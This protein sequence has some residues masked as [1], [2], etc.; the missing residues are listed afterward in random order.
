M[1]VNVNGLLQ[2]EYAEML[3]CGQNCEIKMNKELVNQNQN[4]NDLKELGL[5]K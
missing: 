2:G 1:R 4:S 3:R 5:N